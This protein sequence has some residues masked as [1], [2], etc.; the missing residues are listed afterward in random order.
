MHRLVL[1]LV[2]LY[3]VLRLLLVLL[4][5]LLLLCIVGLFRYFLVLFFLLL[6]ELRPLLLLLCVLL[7]L[8]LLVLLVE[9]RIARIWSRGTLRWWK[10]ADMAR[11]RGIVLGTRSG[12]ATISWRRIASTGFARFYDVTALEIARFARRAAR[13]S[14]P[15]LAPPDRQP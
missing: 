5:H 9:L 3:Q 8:F 4:F 12:S 11:S 14:L 10:V 1:L 7:V 13:Q 6:L 15:N 2:P